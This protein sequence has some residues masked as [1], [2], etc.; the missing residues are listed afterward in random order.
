MMAKFAHA[1]RVCTRLSFPPSPQEPANEATQMSGGW[2]QWSAK[3]CK[4]NMDSTV[5]VQMPLHSV[6]INL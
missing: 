6:T 1:P 5:T 2:R 3:T 4:N